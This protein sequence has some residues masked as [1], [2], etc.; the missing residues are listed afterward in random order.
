MYI[1]IVVIN[2]IY[3]KPKTGNKMATVPTLNQQIRNGLSNARLSS[4]YQNLNVNNSAGGVVGYNIQRN[5]RSVV[6]N[7]QTDFIVEQGRA[8][9]NVTQYQF[10]SDM[11]NFH[12]R[13]IENEW[14]I[15]SGDLTMEKFYTL[16]L[17]MQGIEDQFTVSYDT[18]YSPVTGLLSQ[19]AE[20]T[21]VSNI[22]GEAARAFQAVSGRSLNVFKQ[23]TLASPE[24]REFNFSWKLSPKNFDESQ[25]I[26]RIYWSLRRGMTPAT[27]AGKL[28]FVFPKIYTMYFVPNVKY[29]YKF[30]PCVLKGLNVNFTG[31]N[32]HPTFYKRQ[33]APTEAPPESVIITMNF[34]ELEYWR[35]QDV[36]SDVNGLPT[37]DPFDVWNF[38]NTDARNAAITT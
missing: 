23:I 12:F 20:A 16:P 19:L 6:G 11:P 35:Q 37:N 38:Y 15:A 7:S 24:F 31:G 14:S 18:N 36:N 25:Q 33:G 9:S 30:K 32:P 13:L 29:L 34:L 27:T 8:A 21:G 26:Q 4:Q 3:Y 1:Y 17:P 2:I 10:P 28:L 22:A 5:T